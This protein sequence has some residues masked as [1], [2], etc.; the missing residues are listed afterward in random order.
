MHSHV[1]ERQTPLQAQR[2]QLIAQQVQ[3][4]LAGGGHIEHITVISIEQRIT[5]VINNRQLTSNIR[6]IKLDK[7][8]KLR[9]EGVS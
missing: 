5:Q 2:S 7:L 9:Q 8:N 1:T 6:K 3:T 4:F